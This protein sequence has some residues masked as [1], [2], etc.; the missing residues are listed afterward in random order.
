MVLSVPHTGSKIDSHS[1]SQSMTD[2]VVGLVQTLSVVMRSR[3]HMLSIC[4]N[5]KIYFT[6]KIPA[7]FCNTVAPHLSSMAVA[8]YY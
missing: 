7:G 8:A 4:E 3:R 6:Q 2:V 1:N 5:K